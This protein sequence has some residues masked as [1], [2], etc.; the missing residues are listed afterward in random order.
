[1]NLGQ[2]LKSFRDHWRAF[3]PYQPGA[4]SEALDALGKLEKPRG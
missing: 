4:Q 1:M 2:P 3:P